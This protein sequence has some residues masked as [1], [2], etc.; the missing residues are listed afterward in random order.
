MLEE[1]GLLAAFY[2]DSSARSPLGR[3]MR[4][5]GGLTPK[6]GALDRWDVKGVPAQ[7]IRSSDL[8]GL[9]EKIIRLARPSIPPIEVFRRRHQLLSG[10]MK[11]WGTRDANMVYSMFHENL[12]FIRYAKSRGAL[13]V[14]D[15]Y[16]SPLTE[17]VMAEEI[18][19]FPDWGDRADPKAERVLNEL[20]DET[21]ELGDVLL[22]PSEWVADGV[23]ERTPAAAPKIKVV[24]Y[25]CTMDFEGR[26]NQPTPGRVLFAGRDPLRK[27]LR[28]LASAATNLKR[29]HP[30]I[31][32]RVAGFMPE[33]VARHPLCAD[34]NFL[35]QLDRA[36]LREEFLSA[37]VFVL[38]ALS[39]GFAGVVAEAI[40]AGC[41]VIVTKEAGSPVV[42]GREGLIVPVG[43]PDALTA[44]I[45]RL[46]TDRALRERCA[47][48]CLKQVPFYSGAA[49]R[50]R[51]TAALLEA[52]A[53]R[54]AG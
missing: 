42:D 46:T 31:D 7:K 47:A 44:A 26:T 35:G 50:Q 33:Q 32:A 8:P 16:V 45:E 22:C 14:V 36:S 6:F 9:Y 48:E 10:K 34:L 51:L 20:W 4:R 13:S 29:T 18:E 17:R 23:R 52:D 24:P 41:P 37:D 19:R 40:G 2:T 3:C 1:E 54:A 25:G 53:A 5:L 28:H 43:D 21:A 27:G 49:W 12:D 15:V 30:N 38:P 11:R 39:E